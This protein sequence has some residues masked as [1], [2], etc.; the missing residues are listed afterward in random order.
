VSWWLA[1]GLS[2]LVPSSIRALRHCGGSRARRIWCAFTRDYLANLVEAI[3]AVRDHGGR[4]DVGPRSGAMGA[5]M[6]ASSEIREARRPTATF[7]AGSED[8]LDAAVSLTTRPRRRLRLRPLW[9]MGSPHDLPPPFALLAA[10]ASRYELV[11]GRS[12]RGGNGEHRAP[13]RAVSHARTLRAGR[14]SRPGTG[15]KLSP[16]RRAYG[17]RAFDASERRALLVDTWRELHGIVPVWFGAGRTRPTSLRTVSGRAQPLGRSPRTSARGECGP[18]LGWS[19]PQDLSAHST[20]L[21]RRRDVGHLRPRS[22]SRT[23]KWE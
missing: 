16:R 14:S 6:I 20:L 22:T 13:G 19:A 18:P 3:R 21:T 17:L 8:A 2:N 23:S 1:L 10:V 7:R 12:W 4:F 11:V 15:D 9:P 5:A